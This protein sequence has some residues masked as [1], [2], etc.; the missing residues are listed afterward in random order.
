[1]NKARLLA[2]LGIVLL[3]GCERREQGA[4]RVVVIGDNPAVVD[5][6]AG[7]LTEPQAVLLGAA[8]Q[9]LVRFDP[10]GNIVAGLAE[11]W[12]VS[13]DGLSYIFRLRSG[14]WPGGR[15]I[16]ADDVARLLRRNIAR[17]SRNPLKDTAG[18]VK[19]IVAMTDRVLAIELAAPRPHLLQLLAQPEFAL[20]RGGSGSGPFTIST[21]GQGLRLTR[22]LPGPEDEP[23]ETETVELA[24]VPV[25]A[26]VQRFVAGQADVV[27]GGRVADLPVALGTRLPRGSLRFDPAAGLFGLVPARATGLA[28][29]RDVR[30]LLD[31]ALDRDALVAAL[32][33]PNLQPRLSI[34]EPGLDSGIPPA[35]PRWT[36]QPLADRRA[37]LLAEAPRF[38]PAQPEGSTT[39]PVIQVGLPDGP[40]GAILL[41]RLRADWGALGFDVEQA[42]TERSADF[43]FVDQVAPSMSPAWYLRSFRCG[44]VPVCSEEADTRLEAARMTLDARERARLFY[45]AERL[46]RDRVLFLPIATPVRWSLVARLPGFVENRFARHG[47][48]DLRA[49]PE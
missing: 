12:N 11:R 5:P 34:L 46:M 20:V 21:Q 16:R 9:G 3:A 6:A 31:Q 8:A 43:R 25:E 38:L 18:A 36:E 27:L 32:S 19:Q 49:R 10:Q 37:A 14:E 33:V 40:G 47:L 41:A 26:A 22:E 29:D 17:A 39:R 4:V 1:M 44:A 24:A 7:P 45:E 2:L 23:T 13:D 30:S 48:T 15:R 42:E 28:A 35:I